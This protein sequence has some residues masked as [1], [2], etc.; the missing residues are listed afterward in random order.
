MT[1]ETQ[2]CN[3]W[4]KVIAI[5]KPQTELSDSVKILVEGGK[6]G[7]FC[8]KAYMLDHLGPKFILSKQNNVF[9]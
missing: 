7:T 8:P 5:T 4:G 6:I 1:P 2:T 3:C 9:I